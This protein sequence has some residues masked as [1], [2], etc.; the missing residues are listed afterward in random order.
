LASLAGQSSFAGYELKTIDPHQFLGLE[1]NP[2]AVAIT[3]LVLWIGLLQWHFRTRGGMRPSRFCA[4]SRRLRS[5]VLGWD[6]KELA[7]DEHARPVARTDTEGKKV[8][9][10]RYKNPKRPEWPE[11]DYIVGNP[12][13][14][15]GKDIR[16]GLGEDYAKALWAVH[17]HMNESADYVMYRWDFA[18]ELLTRN[19]ARLKRFSLVTTNSLSQV[20]QRRVTEKHLGAKIPFRP[21]APARAIFFEESAGAISPNA[22]RSD[23]SPARRAPPRP[24]PRPPPCRRGRARDHAS[25]PSR[26]PRPRP[27]DRRRELRHRRSGGS[28]PS[29]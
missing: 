14:T 8:E 15:G 27:A 18:A 2:R 17:P 16:G 28:A 10:Y 22:W 24:L 12:P 11:A 25:T 7:R 3:E 9:V 1:V 5:A 21:K 23:E 4:I 19:D 13:F 20:F 6:A 26:A 29:P